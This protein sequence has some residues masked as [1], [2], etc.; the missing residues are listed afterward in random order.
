MEAMWKIG[1]RTSGVACMTIGERGWDMME[2]RVLAL[3]PRPVH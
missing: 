1:K 3:L 2:E